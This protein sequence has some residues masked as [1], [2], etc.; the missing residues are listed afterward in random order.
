MVRWHIIL[1]LEDDPDLG[2]APWRDNEK[3]SAP[4]DAK[5]LAAGIAVR[6]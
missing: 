1:R 5:A 2:Q 6:L 3:T 4:D